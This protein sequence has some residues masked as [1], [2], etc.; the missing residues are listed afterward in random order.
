MIQYIR[1]L[2]RGK[3]VSNETPIN[4]ASVLCALLFS[5]P[6]VFSTEPSTRHDALNRVAALASV[7][8]AGTSYKFPVFLLLLYV[9]RQSNLPSQTFLHILYS[10]M[11]SLVDPNDPT[12]TAKI[13]QLIHPLM[14]SGHTMQIRNTSMASVGYR[15][16]VKIYEQQPRAWQELKKF[17]TNWILSRKSVSYVTDDKTAIQMEIVVLTSMRDLCRTRARET[18]QDIL[19]MLVSL[20]QSCKNLSVSSM[21]IIVE[22]VCACVEAGLAEPRPIWNVAVSYIAEYAMTCDQNEVAILWEKLGCFF[23]IVGDKDEGKSYNLSVKGVF[24]SII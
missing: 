7:P 17:M 20:L 4:T 2:V 5:A 24:S 12:T 19:P 1:N 13:L 22:A 23:A 11:P 14:Y 15:V 18:A 16:L 6:D 21:A 8:H 10:V 3:S 9:L